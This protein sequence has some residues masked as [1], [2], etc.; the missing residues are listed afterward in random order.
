MSSADHLKIPPA[1]LGD[2]KS[3]ELLRVWVASGRQHVSLRT[4]VWSDA[5]AW[6]I[7]LADLARHIALSHASTY[8]ADV[9]A[10]LSRVKAGFDAEFGS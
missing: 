7:M 5:A 9:A 4:D 1:A 10:I 8:D 6:G 2:G 3:V